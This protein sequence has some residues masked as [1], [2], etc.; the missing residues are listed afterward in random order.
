MLRVKRPVS[1]QRI[2]KPAN[3]CA[4]DIELIINLSRCGELFILHNHRDIIN[5]PL[6]WQ[7]Q[8]F[9]FRIRN[10]YQPRQP[11][12]DLSAGF[13]MLMRMEPTGR[14]PLRWSKGHRAGAS[15]GN[16]ALGTAVNGAGNLQTVPVYGG[17]LRQPVMNIDGCLLPLLKL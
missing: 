13:A 7:E 1:Q 10:Q 12:R 8:L 3:G 11:H 5:S 4:H 2:A 16:H 15:G 6:L 17:L 9:A 14:R